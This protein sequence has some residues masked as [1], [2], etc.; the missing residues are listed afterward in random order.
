MLARLCDFTGSYCVQDNS[1]PNG[2]PR[3]QPGLR[4]GAGAILV[5]GRAPV[6]RRLKRTIAWYRADHAA[7]GRPRMRAGQQVAV[8]ATDRP[9]LPGWAVGL[10]RCWWCWWGRWRS[11]R[12]FPRP[13]VILAL[14]LLLRCRLA[15]A[16]RPRA[17]WAMPA[18]T[19]FCCC[20]CWPC[21]GVVGDAAL[22]RKQ[23]GPN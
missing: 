2:Q 20:C 17:A 11:S 5:G 13:G 6:G 22:L 3:L 18:P 7:Q 1:K 15:C 19:P 12:F 14:L 16:G 8:P 4:P 10:G 23:R 9:A 21:P